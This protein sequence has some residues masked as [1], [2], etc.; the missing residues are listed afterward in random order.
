[1]IPWMRAPSSAS[2]SPGSLTIPLA[3]WILAKRLD[4]R[5]IAIMILSASSA[6][7]RRAALALRFAFRFSRPRPMDLVSST[8]A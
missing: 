4:S 7:R 8:P 2:D 5:L 1:M 3:S 6:S